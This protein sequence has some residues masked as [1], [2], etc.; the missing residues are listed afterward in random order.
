MR[1]LRDLRRHILVACAE[2][3]HGEIRTYVG[4]HLPE[5]ARALRVEPEKLAQT[6]EE[7]RDD[8][9]L[10]TRLLDMATRA[11]ALHR[12]YR[13]T[14][15]LLDAQAAADRLGTTVQWRGDAAHLDVVSLLATSLTRRQDVLMF[16]SEDFVTS[17]PMASL[18][19]LSHIA[20]VRADL[21]GFV[22]REA[23]HLR[24]RSGALNLVS[25]ELNKRKVIT[26]TINLPA[27]AS[28][29]A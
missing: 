8:G 16:I 15:R 9:A 1:M 19:D 11:E 26:V 20:R 13:R 22:T 21:T 14:L 25:H 4:E 17:V 29:A 23:L 28:V 6:I 10:A 7:L 18:L 24:W 5:L 3:E 27:R 12:A 2:G